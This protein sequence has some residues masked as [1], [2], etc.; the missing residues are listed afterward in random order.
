MIPVKLALRNFMS[1]TDIHDPLLFDGIHVAC[2][3]GENGAGKSALLD[4]ITWAL[5]GQSRARTADQLVHTGRT[6]MEVELEFILADA[7]YRVV[8]KRTTTGR[9]ST[10]LDL[11]VRDDGTF[12]SMSGNSINETEAKIEDLLRMSYT[13]FTNSSFV[14]QGRADS[15]TTRTPAERKQV[16]AEILELSEYDRLQE[17]ARSEVQEREV[18]HRQLEVTVREADAEL[19][20]RPT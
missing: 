8:R 1:Y 16:L 20:R 11:A 5:W 19:E 12:R 6:D 7:H 4:A 10:V 18:R 13:T 9:G 2:L 3:S 15:F 17:R 14:L